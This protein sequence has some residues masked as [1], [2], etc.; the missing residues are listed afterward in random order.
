VARQG[1]VT[2]MAPARRCAAGDDC[3]MVA[4]RTA[5]QESGHFAPLTAALAADARE[6]DGGASPVV[7]DVSAGT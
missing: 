6:V 3:G 1:Y 5:I 4:A 7:L 2:L